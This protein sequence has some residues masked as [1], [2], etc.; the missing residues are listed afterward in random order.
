M[1]PLLAGSKLNGPRLDAL[2]PQAAM[3]GGEI[4]LLGLGLQGRADRSLPLVRIGE[5]QAHLALSRP[6]R[7][8]IRILDSTISGEVEVDTGSGT[9]N[10]LGLRVAVPMAEGL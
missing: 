3:P 8:T 7:A 6:D 5:A 9:S 10:R 2:R 4:E 1:K